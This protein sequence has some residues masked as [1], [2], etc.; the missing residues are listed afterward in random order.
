MESVAV[1][2][3]N[4]CWWVPAVTFICVAF[5]PEN[6]VGFV[7]TQ[8]QPSLPPPLFGPASV[9][10]ESSTQTVSLH[11]SPPPPCT[12]YAVGPKS[13]MDASEIAPARM[14]SSAGTLP[15]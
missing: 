6:G 14:M 13:D 15:A 12:K 1:A 9:G 2:E 8:F 3:S 4:T 10:K 11:I 5:A 7:L